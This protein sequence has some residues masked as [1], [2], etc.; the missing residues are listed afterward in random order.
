MSILSKLP[1]DFNKLLTGVLLVEEG[2]PYFKYVEGVK[3]EVGGI[4]YNILVPSLGYKTISVKVEN[5]STPSICYIGTPIP[6]SFTNARGK[7]YQDFQKGGEIKLSI[8]A[9]S[10]HIVEKTRLRMNKEE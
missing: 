4:A 9:D 6:V 5:E 8:V 1:I 2:H 7:A 10:I 3:T